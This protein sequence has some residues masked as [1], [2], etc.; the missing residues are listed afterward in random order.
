MRKIIFTLFI[1]VCFHF[2]AVSQAVIDTAAT[3]VVDADQDAELAYNK[4]IELYSAKQYSEAV[5]SFSD[6]I[7]VNP[8]FV[9]AYMNRAA[10]RTE[11]KDFKGAAE[12]YGVVIELDSAEKRAFYKRGMCFYYLNDHDAAYTELEK[13][14]KTP[15]ELANV[16]YY[17]GI[18]SFLKDS[19]NLAN[20]HFS[21][22]I[23][24]NP[25]FANAYNDRASAKKKLK[26]TLGAIADYKLAIKY[27]DK[28]AIA[29]NN[30]ASL[31]RRQ[32]K[33]DLAIEYY[34]QAIAIDPKYYMALNN[35]GSAKTDNGM[36]DEAVA[37]FKKAV[38]VKNDYYY[39]YNNMGVAYM[40]KKSYGMA[41]IALT[42]AIELNPE[43]A[44]A[45]MNRGAVLEMMRE[46]KEACADWQTAVDKGLAKAE[47]YLAEC[48]N[49][50]KK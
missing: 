18:I 10:V 39:A 27:N 6:A 30:L 47:I 46:A 28:L 19:F 32:G 21:G 2:A 17:L 15:F 24:V 33:F 20:E 11:L 31:Y 48:P 26:D 16:Y 9:K 4:G 37:D 23:R 12:D 5:K 44:P 49:Y 50:S 45:Y 43:Y 38:L 1:A 35:R 22:A 8:K 42:K 41:K 40:K 29:Y 13:A 14:S 25:K 7:A 34:D 36:Y 3:I